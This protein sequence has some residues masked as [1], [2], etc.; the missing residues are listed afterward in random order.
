MDLANFNFQHF[1]I[2]ELIKFLPQDISIRNL[3]DFRTSR[4]KINDEVYSVAQN[5]DF[6]VVYGSENIYYTIIVYS[7]NPNT[8]IP[9]LNLKFYTKDNHNGLK[10][11]IIHILKTTSP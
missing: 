9:M 11:I 2:S 10:E 4:K 6:N 1:T 7:E 5:I 3:D 8:K